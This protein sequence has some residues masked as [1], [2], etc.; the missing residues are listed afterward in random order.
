MSSSKR[1]LGVFS[2]AMITV[3]SVDSIRNLPA[4]ALFGST[5][6]FFFCLAALLFLL[7]SALV[8]A[9]LASNSREQGGIYVWVKEAF[10]PR[11][12]C[13][14]VWYQWVSNVIWYPTIL[15][16]VAA[17]LGY[18][19]APELASNRW[20]LVVTI[21]VTFWLATFSNLLGMRTS[22]LV[23]NICAILGLLIPMGLI[24]FLGLHWLFAGQPLAVHFSA[25]SVLPH[26][27]HSQMWV[28]LTAIMLSFCGMEIATVH[29]R[30]VHQP[31]RA[32]PWAMLIATVL[33]LVTLLGGSLAIAFVVPTKEISLV[34]GI[35]Q[36]FQYYFQAF[37]W[38][39]VLPVL[40][41]MLV[42]GG[43]GGVNNWIIAP[44][45]GLQLAADDA[46]LPV[47]LKVNNRY[48]APQRLLLIQ[49]VLVSL[50]CAVFFIFPSINASY[51]W[52][53]VLAAQL[54][55]VMYVIMFVVAIVLRRRRRTHEHS[56][57]I[58]GGKL[59]LW[60]VVVA[61]TVSAVVT[62]LISYLPPALLPP[63]SVNH[64]ELMLVVGLVC[65]SMPPWVWFCF[66]KIKARSETLTS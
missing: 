15:S 17:T 5:L 1:P 4:T 54:Y 45:R 18:L 10:G 61:G 19:L 65:L 22:A 3:G 37:H 38:H 30:S 44:T 13:L 11:M 55:M 34:A 66:Q 8:S 53:N 46:A 32:Y 35:M 48:G 43:F 26:W 23:A 14:A 57:E 63:G 6:V 50:L 9:E 64:Y 27:Q 16:F 20:F 41:L 47:W 51:L 49:A 2:L 25:Q 36:T 56:F 7:P 58:P 12:G 60:V 29:G 40:G 21:V 33:L 28:A 42:I 24:I 52:L 62:I 31:H 39:G 59:A